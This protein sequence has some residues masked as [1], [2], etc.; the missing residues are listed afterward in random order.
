MITKVNYKATIH[1]EKKHPNKKIVKIIP[2]YKINNSHQEINMS[3]LKSK[4]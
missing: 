4:D 1:Q 2:K 3:E